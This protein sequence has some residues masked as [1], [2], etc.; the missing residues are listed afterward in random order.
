MEAIDE[1]FPRASAAAMAAS[2]QRGV[3]PGARAAPTAAMPVCGE[4]D[5]DLPA[6][7]AFGAVWHVYSSQSTARSSEAVSVVALFLVV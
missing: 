1:I 7:N 6:L 2:L 5:S 3:E 4:S